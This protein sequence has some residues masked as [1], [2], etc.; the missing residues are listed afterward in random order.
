MRTF[1]FFVATALGSIVFQISVALYP[2]TLQHYGWLV[3]WL[4]VA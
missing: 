2:Q 3:K 4:W 1:L